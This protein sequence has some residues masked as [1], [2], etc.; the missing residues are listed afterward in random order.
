MQ[1]SFLATALFMSLRVLKTASYAG[2]SGVELSFRA[3]WR[4]S[5]FFFSYKGGSFA[6]A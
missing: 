6:S 3:Y 5:F 2:L 1:F 4:E